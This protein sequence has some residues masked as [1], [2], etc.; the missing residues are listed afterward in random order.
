MSVL[1]L[2]RAQ[3]QYSHGLGDGCP[4]LPLTVV[5]G[6]FHRRPC[7]AAVFCAELRA[8]RATEWG[9][10]PDLLGPPGAIRIWTEATSVRRMQTGPESA[11]M[12]ALTAVLTGGGA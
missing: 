7:G 9:L 12:P 8:T 4:R 1:R 2:R 5:K 11:R 3:K 10:A 6:R